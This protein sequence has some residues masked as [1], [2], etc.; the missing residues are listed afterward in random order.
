MKGRHHIVIESP[1]LKY[2]FDVKRNI[3]IIKGDSATGKTTLIELLNDYRSEE[4]SAVQVSSDVPCRVFADNSPTWQQALEIIRDSIVFIDED[5]TFIRTREFAGLLKKS[6][7]YFVLITREALTELP[8]SIHEI[9]GIRTT[10]KFHFP[11]Q[12][13]HE[14]YPIYPDYSLNAPIED[15]QKKVSV[16]TPADV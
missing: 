16:P 15:L 13:Y 11:E 2:E 7:N 10:G 12:I 14:F 9:Y 3:T 6:T 8:Y 5:N 1:R 4:D